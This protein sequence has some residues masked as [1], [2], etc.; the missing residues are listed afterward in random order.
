VRVLIYAHDTFG[1]GHVS[2]A[3]KLAG[4]CTR[5]PET[6]VLIATGTAVP[7]LKDV[8]AGVDLVKIPSLR[9]VHS[10]TLTFQSF[11]TSL[12]GEAI[13][14]IRSGLLKTLVKEF[15]PDLLL[16]D[17]F[18]K[19]VEGE[20]EPAIRLAKR[21][22]A[23][24]CLVLRDVLGDPNVVSAKWRQ[25]GYLPF[26]SKYFH[27]V[28]VFGDRSVLDIAKAYKLDFIE[29][30]IKYMGYLISQCGSRP[31]SRQILVTTG[32]GRDG[33]SIIENLL[34][35][36]SP[37]IR[38]RYFVVAGP[39]TPG[40]AWRKITGPKIIRE[41]AALVELMNRSAMTICM[42]GYNTLCEVL[43]TRTPALVIPRTHPE[44]EQ[45]IR[46]SEFEKR[47]MLHVL[48][49]EDVS[50][51]KLKKAM[52]KTVHL[53]LTKADYPNLNGLANFLRYIK[54]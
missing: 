51:E 52:K 53:D 14:R 41:T 20:L 1:M 2:R 11:N 44:T 6:T 19:G 23:K 32:G 49:Q 22:G 27:H 37:Q 17:L 16:V 47:G 45:W 39:L 40:E 46:A 29:E 7:S 48:R 35:C 34:K 43:E 10:N 42:G 8:P 33:I 12:S 15:S 4:V 54:G 24:I 26:I 36:S 25:Q 31:R 28:L 5:L 9:S 3:L 50:A 30:K 18:P 38:N 13:F 21:K